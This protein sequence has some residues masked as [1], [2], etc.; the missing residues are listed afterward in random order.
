MAVQLD[1]RQEMAT[2]TAFS[3]CPQPQG[4]WVKQN[5]CPGCRDVCCHPLGHW[6]TGLDPNSHTIKRYT[7]P[8]VWED[9]HLS[10]QISSF[11]HGCRLQC[12]SLGDWIENKFWANADGSTMCAG[13]YADSNVKHA[14]HRPVHVNPREV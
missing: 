11:H 9:S 7:V 13:G 5:G 3:T 10:Q 1:W 8:E 14:P 12:G 6:S 4:S 2:L